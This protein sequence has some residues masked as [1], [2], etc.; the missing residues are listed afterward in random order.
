MKKL[1]TLILVILSVSIF[2]ANIQ[3]IADVQP[4]PG[5]KGWADYS[6]VHW[7]IFDEVGERATY[8]NAEDFDMEYPVDFLAVQALLYEDD[9]NYHFKIYDK[10]GITVIWEQETDSI[11]AEGA[12][13]LAYPLAP[14]ILT[15]DFW[16]ALVGSHAGGKVP[17]TVTD[18]GDGPH[19]A[20]SYFG[21]ADAWT[22]VDPIE[23]N[24]SMLVHI[25]PST[26]ILPPIVREVTGN[27][28]FMGTDATVFAKVFSQ[29]DVDSISGQ[30][31]IEGAP[32]E[33]IEMSASKSTSYYSGFVPGQ[34]DGTL[35]S[36]RF[37]TIDTLGNEGLSDEFPINWS[38][39]NTMLDESFE[40]EWLPSGWSLNSV[41][42]GF[43]NT[44]VATGQFAHDGVKSAGHLDDEGAQDDWLITPILN[45]PATNSC[46]LSFWQNG[47]WLEYAG[48]H[49]VSVTVVGSGTW[50]QIYTGL[51]Q[52]TPD[53]E[54]GDLGIWEQIMI[55]LMDYAGDDIQIGFH[56]VGD[57]NAM[58]YIDEVKVAYDYEGP[59]PVSVIGNP[60]LVDSLGIGGF[61]NNDLVLSVTAY[62]LT[63][64]QS[65]I[66]H[67]SVDGGAVIDLPFT[68][69]KSG[70]EV[71]TAFIPAEAAPTTG[72]INFDM[73]D[74]GGTASPTTADYDFEF[75]IDEFPP[76]ITSF[77][78]GKPIFVNTDMNLVLK[79]D[80]ESAITSCSASYTDGDGTVPV[81]MTPSKINNYTYVGIVPAKVVETFGSVAFS[82]KDVNGDSV[83]SVD[84]DVEWFEGAEQFNDD[85]DANHTPS[86][87]T[88]DGDWVLTEEDSHTAT[89]SLTESEGGNYPHDFNFS[90]TINT[91]M[92]FSTALSASL[93]L[94]KKIDTELDWDF[95]YVEGSTDGGLNWTKMAEFHGYG[96]D[97]EADEVSLG[98]FAGEATVQIRFRWFCD[99]NTGADGA[100]LDDIRI[101]TFDNDHSDPVITY[102]G[103]SA[104]VVGLV[105]YV[106]N[107][108]L[109]DIS[110]IS[111]TK[112][113]YTV[114]G[115]AEQEVLAVPSFGPSGTYTYTIPAQP[116]GSVI[117]YKI[118]AIDDS[119]FLNTA[120]TEMYKVIFGNYLYY[121]NGGGNIDY[122][123][124]IGPTGSALAIAK[125]LTIEPDS[126]T[127]DHYKSTLVGFTID[128]YISLPD[129]PSAPMYIH[130]WNDTG[131]GPGADMIV[132]F[133]QDQASI[134]GD[135]YAITMV[136]LRPYA[137]QLTDLEG[138]V[139]VGFT[140]S[141]DATNILYEVAGNHSGVPGYTA[142]E[143][144]WLGTGH[145]DT[146]SWSLDASSVY[147][148]S[149]ITTDYTLIDAPLA[150]LALTAV[151]VDDMNE[152]VLLNW[153]EGVDFDLDYYNVYRGLTSGF[154][155]GAP[156]GT[157]DASV[158]T[159][160]EDISP[161]EIV[162]GS[163]FYKVTAVD[164][165]G[166]ESIPS[167]EVEVY[168]DSAID[169]NIPMVTSL[170]QNYPNP[171][172]P[173]TTIN[174]S[175]AIEG[176][177]SLTV[178]NTA[179]AVVA[180]LVDGKL[181]RGYHSVPF[182]GSRLVSGVY[183]YTM[184]LN[185]KVFT[186]KMMLLK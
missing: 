117:D 157:V 149:G 43:I 66:G 99:D 28:C 173:V 150:P 27:E 89:H 139:Y 7:W 1:V 177:V 32:W 6:G 76:I 183:Y 84:Y 29:N 75:I 101:C 121:E 82:I 169:G 140:S 165:G 54:V 92:D 116:A 123:D 100:W 39:D 46:T 52:L 48:L 144:S 185:D 170:S 154:A 33:Y 106:I 24:H 179:G 137:A 77:T 56:Y 34:V 80:D 4:K 138:N 184:Q 63:G 102:D 78:Y 73:I 168:F 10:D 25:E 47:E 162:T 13:Q 136:D 91:V 130:V 135:S 16:I 62:D 36:L 49:E 31:S 105:D 22:A 64:V 176:N 163:Y 3:R 132:P 23:R 156:I 17:K 134:I 145:I 14:V 146:L 5:S 65:I 20:H 87:W 44:A 79:F 61:V 96:G 171:F 172:N 160:Y 119:P 115:G 42:A 98:A 8:Y 161:I 153:A 68:A 15:D 45:I 83:Y 112:V 167:K 103:P 152:K 141:G 86:D 124:T 151:N 74:L 35:G 67:Y 71:W 9:V 60:A 113:I 158:G 142:F 81:V 2:A 97:W 148:M 11:A 50:T 88:F 26:T 133:L 180:K 129:Y 181:D 174:F 37:T 12:W 175:T 166:Q 111:E 126:L 182:D 104:T 58:W 90:A 143:R 41:G 18:D 30:Y 108:D 72:V 114:D 107:A 70:N 59:V 53:G 178:Y 131:N 69:A 127:K 19:G 159:T 186:H 85:F 110:D 94:W 125:R 51:P 40:G 118:V 164:E 38:K 122:P 120:E 128:N 93:Y 109:L 57:F 155:L 55:S 95:V 147:H 21:T